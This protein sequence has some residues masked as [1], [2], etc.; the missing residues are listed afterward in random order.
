MVAGNESLFK[1]VDVEVAIGDSNWNAL[2]DKFLVY[3]V[4]K[5]ELHLQ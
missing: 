2:L 1:D 3:V 4:R 5:V